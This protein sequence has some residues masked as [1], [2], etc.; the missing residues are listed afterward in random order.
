MNP[1]DKLMPPF[2]ETKRPRLFFTHSR[3][4]QFRRRIKQEGIIQDAWQNLLK[5]ADSLLDA[6]FVSEEY[7]EEGEGQHGNYGRPS[8]QVQG[9]GGMLGLAYHMTGDERYAQKLKEA[10]LYY[11]NYRR[12]CG[13]QFTTWDPPWHSE[14]NTAR[15]CYGYAL[16]YDCIYDFLSK[17]EKNE[18][19]DS[20]VR[21]G[22]LP[23]LEDWILPEKR[24]HALDSMGHNWWSVCVAMAG[25]AALSLLGDKPQA[26]VW[27]SSVS[28]AF[29]EWFYYK[30][31]VLQ[32]KPA[33]FDRFGAFYESVGYA[34]Y[35][36]SEY[37]MYQLA[38][39]NMLLD[40]PIPDN[41][42]LDE[43]GDFFLHTSY[44]TSKSLLSLNFGD[45]GIN[46]DGSRTIR[47]LLANGYH[48]DQFAWYLKQTDLGLGDPLALVYCEPE[49]EIISPRDYPISAIYPDI[50]WGIMRSSWKN[51]ATLLAVKSGFTWNHAH[52][53]AGSFIVFHGGK[54]LIIDSGAC[55]YSRP[56]YTGYYCQSEA[57]NVMLFDGK[58][59]SREDIPRGV[60]FPGSVYNLTD[61]GGLKY[62]FA[63]ATGPMAQHFS[64]N[65]RHF[66]WIDSAILVID[67]VRAHSEGKFEWLL[68]YEGEAQI[69]DSDISLSN[70][71]AKAVVCP[72]YPE[73]PLIIEKEGLKDHA[74]DEKANYF[75]L[76]TNE[77]S[78]DAKFIIAIIPLGKG[79]SKPHMERIQSSEVFGVRIRE[80][81]MVNDIYLNLRA[82]GRRMHRNSNKSIL[83]WETDAYLLATTRPE[84][85][86]ENDPDSITR[87]F[88]ACGSYLRRDGKVILDSLSKVYAALD[89]S[90]STV[91]L[92]LHGQDL[93]KVKIGIGKKPRKLELN[94]LDADVSYDEKDK[95][96]TIIVDE[97]FMDEFSIFPDM[98]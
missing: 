19:S 90:K 81:G 47:M 66:L 12:W 97:Y 2:W 3:I 73:K 98:F 63:D 13:M 77:K 67:D 87:Y 36:L 27:V 1:S 24:V 53:D 74:P 6:E 95:S 43:A 23:T 37:L 96:M 89:R 44:P 29:R 38:C 72:L 86:D 28:D 49:S 85:S 46:S 15:F 9:M 41:G 69:Q 17:E 88:I 50:G 32:N 10:L 33:N 14:L 71:S 59:Q 26:E 30:G 65:Y 93:M 56:E 20:M 7:A 58:G 78:M 48:R 22:I 70:G 21:L 54:P 75:S 8:S 16:G 64:R 62:M 68:H 18:I 84:D 94:N 39:S 31:N 76:Q 5:R 42:I 4:G 25:L 40:V 92:D 51:N 83:G 35:A 55:S 57:H 45:S 34:N 91:R 11:G 52:A 82:D 61:I 60:K 79:K 80:N